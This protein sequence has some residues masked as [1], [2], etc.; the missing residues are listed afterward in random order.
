MRTLVNQRTFKALVVNALLCSIIYGFFFVAT[1]NESYYLDTYECRNTCVWRLSYT[2]NTVS[3]VNTELLST[4]GTDDNSVP[5]YPAYNC[6]QNF[7]NLADWVYGWPNQFKEKI[8]SVSDVHAVSLCLPDGS[9]IYVRGWEIDN[10]FDSVYPKLKSKFVLV[11]GESD[12]SVPQAKHME[13]LNSNASKIIHWFGQNGLVNKSNKYVPF[14]HIPIGINCYEMANGL[15]SVHRDIASSSFTTAKECSA[16][17]GVP[18]SYKLPLDVTERIYANVSLNLTSTKLLLFNFNLDTD[19]TGLRRQIWN[20]ACNTSNPN[21]WLS[22]TDCVQK[23]WSIDVN[24]M[25]NIYARNRK[26]PFWLS[27][28][29]NG[30]DCHRTW[31]ALYMDIIPIVFSSSLNSLY[32]DLPVLIIDEWRDINAEYLSSVLLDIR[33]KKLRNHYD[34]KKLHSCY[35]HDLILSHSKHRSRIRAFSKPRNLCWRISRV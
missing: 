21:N 17:T 9:I 30:L 6:P 22:F 32:S 35:W 13:I 19:R 12:L 31:E 3:F 7:R 34:W 5:V 15:D 25:S 16:Q 29:G 28:R 14:T 26:Y 23:G 24:N 20:Y 11:T 18:L 4:S 1:S 2:R 8:E 27:P 10:F 33:S